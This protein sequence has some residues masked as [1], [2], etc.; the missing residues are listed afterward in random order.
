MSWADWEGDQRS[1]W[2]WLTPERMAI[3]AVVL[4]IVGAIIRGVTG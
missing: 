2:E 3:L 1:A 4:A